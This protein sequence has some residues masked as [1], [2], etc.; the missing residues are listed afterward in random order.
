MSVPP[1]STAAMWTPFTA[2][3]W[4]ELEHQALIFKYL[5]A[6]LSVP[7]DLLLPIRKSLQKILNQPQTKYPK[8]IISQAKSKYPNQSI[9]QVKAKYPN[10]SKSQ[11]KYP[12]QKATKSKI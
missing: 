7:P 6:G 12:K 2:A 9:S 3:Q 4:H 10:Q 11:T 5:K 8:Q 1:P